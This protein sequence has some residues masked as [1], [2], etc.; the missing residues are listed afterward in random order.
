[1][2]RRR[3]QPPRGKLRPFDGASTRLLAE[4]RRHGVSDSYLRQWSDFVRHPRH[5]RWLRQ[6]EAYFDD[7]VVEALWAR[8]Q[9]EHI[10]GKLPRRS[11]RELR[12]I[13]DTLDDLH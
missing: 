3:P 13:I 12:K 8:E 7:D 4:V 9:L 10:V 5:L 2:P 1:M 11:A 6:H